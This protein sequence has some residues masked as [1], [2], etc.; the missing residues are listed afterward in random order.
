MKQCSR[1]LTM[2]LACKKSLHRFLAVETVSGSQHPLF[3]LLEFRF[4]E[5]S[6][7]GKGLVF[8][9]IPLLMPL[10]VV[11]YVLIGEVVHFRKRRF[12]VKLGERVVGIFV[13]NVRHGAVIVGGLTVSPSYRR[14]GVGWFTLERIERMC[15]S[16]NVGWLELSVL[17]KNVPAQHLYKKLGFRKAAERRWSLTLRKKLGT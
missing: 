16:M 13:L 9:N 7:R 12:F 10:L 14:L 17:K 3:N 11:P 8:G 4:F 2:A 6:E 5:S 15:K 1:K